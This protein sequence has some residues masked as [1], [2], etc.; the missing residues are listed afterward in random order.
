MLEWSV[1]YSITKIIDSSS[2]TTDTTM[3]LAKLMSGFWHIFHDRRRWQAGEGVGLHGRCSNPHR[4]SSWWE[5][6]QHQAL[7]QQ[8]HPNQHQRRRSHC[9][10]EVPSPFYLLMWRLEATEAM[11][12]VSPQ[13]DSKYSTFSLNL[14][15]QKM[16][17]I[18]QS[19]IHTEE[20]IYTLFKENKCNFG[21]AW[22][23]LFPCLSRKGWRMRS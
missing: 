8:Q 3:H 16:L 12:V 18:Q 5:H 22:L 10:M 7:L 17:R 23:R 19:Y 11:Y 6:H 14:S 21:E 2:P 1:E 13:S 20:W 15:T 9:P 4:N